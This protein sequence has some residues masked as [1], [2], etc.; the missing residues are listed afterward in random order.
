LNALTSL[1]EKEEK[2]E[3]HAVWEQWGTDEIR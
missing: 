3:T 2:K 1:D